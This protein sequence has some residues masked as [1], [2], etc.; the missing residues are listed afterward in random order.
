M[1]LLLLTAFLFACEAK[2]VG[3]KPYQPDELMQMDYNAPK[4]RHFDSDGNL[5]V[6]YDV[7]YKELFLS[8]QIEYDQTQILI[9]MPKAFDAKLT[10][11]MKDAG[12]VSLEKSTS[13]DKTVWYQAKNHRQT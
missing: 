6:T 8:G 11:E 10:Q 7:A 4:E 2:Q 9:K 5:L 12:L 13:N 1:V 3:I